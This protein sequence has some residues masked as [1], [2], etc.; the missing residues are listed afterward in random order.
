MENEKEKI[1]LATIY[2]S[3]HILNNLLNQLQFIK[4]EIDS[5]SSIDP[6]TASTLD[7]ILEEGNVLME[8][9]SSVKSMDEGSIKSSVT[10]EI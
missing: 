5:N 7:S 10:P 6:T 2:G 4:M 9:L 1:Y 3:Q 8:K